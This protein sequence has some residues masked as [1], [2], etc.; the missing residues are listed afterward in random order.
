MFSRRTLQWL[1]FLVFLCAAH[2]GWAQADGPDALV[3]RVSTDVLAAVNADPSIQAGDTDRTVALVDAKIL[4]F[5]D[6]ERMTATAVGPRWVDASAE[7]KQRLQQEFKTLLVRVYSSA[8]AQSKDKTIDV[9][10]LR[11]PA[12]GAETVVQTV[13][14][15]GQEPIG[16][17]FRVANSP[18]GWKVHDL[19]VGRVWLIALY[20]DSFAQTLASGGVDGLIAALS[21]KNKAAPRK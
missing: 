5:L 9:L 7:Q 12:K 19:N 1:S 8:L 3:K 17:D 15:G 13:I 4:P 21:A 11:E 18:S 10:P 6:F 16:L 14:R 20:R 2:V